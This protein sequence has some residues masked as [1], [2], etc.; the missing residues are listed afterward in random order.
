MFLYQENV[1]TKNFAGFHSPEHLMAH[2]RAP[3]ELHQLIHRD[4]GKKEN[5]LSEKKA[6][7]QANK[8]TMTEPFVRA[9]AELTA[10]QRS[11]SEGLSYL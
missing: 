7:I 6:F 10:A 5:H 4:E 2:G 8:R 9:V 1:L 11:T 3:Q